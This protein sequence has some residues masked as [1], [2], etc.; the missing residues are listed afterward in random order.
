MHYMLTYEL[1][2]DYMQRRPQ[3]RGEH[4]ALAW[5]AAERG[6]IML[7]G[8]MDDPQE[9]ALL[10]RADSEAVPA[11]FAK[12]DPYVLNGLVTRWRVRPWNTVVGHEASNPLR[13]A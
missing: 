10:F 13:T 1:A 11:A 3:F 9:A 2:P 4:L 8:V 5:Q 6:E 7:A 12:A